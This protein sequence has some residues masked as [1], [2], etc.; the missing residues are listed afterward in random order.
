MIDSQGVVED[1]DNRVG[2]DVTGT[3]NFQNHRDGIRVSGCSGNVIGS[4]AAYFG[5]Y[6]ESNTANGINIMGVGSTGNVIQNNTSISPVLIYYA[7][8][9]SNEYRYY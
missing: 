8:M 6:I 1:V 4:L 2:V 7:M 5:N 3:T 9:T